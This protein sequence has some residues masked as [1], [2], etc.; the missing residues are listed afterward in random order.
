[1]EIK[2]SYMI[3]F[4]ANKFFFKKQQLLDGGDDKEV[5]LMFRKPKTIIA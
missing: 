1:M 3:K 5:T 4:K 2:C